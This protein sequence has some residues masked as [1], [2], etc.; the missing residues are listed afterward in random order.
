MVGIGLGAGELRREQDEEVGD[1]VRER[2]HA[3]GDERLGLR[4]EPASDLRE[5][6]DQIDG[7]PDE[8]DRRMIA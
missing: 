7:G 4:R 2:M 6:E 5:G 1:E 3:V 8:G